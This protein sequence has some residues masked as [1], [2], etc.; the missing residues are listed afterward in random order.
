MTRSERE[1]LLAL[2]GQLREEV[3]PAAAEENA[4]VLAAAKT[5]QEYLE[6]AQQELRLPPREYMA[7]FI[8]QN[9]ALL[10]NLPDPLSYISWTMREEGYSKEEMDE[11]QAAFIEW[12]QSDQAKMIFL[13]LQ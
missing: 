13:S 4:A 2:L 12:Y 10:L 1:N 9:N 6:A 8:D 3:D 11:A 7:Q 5:V